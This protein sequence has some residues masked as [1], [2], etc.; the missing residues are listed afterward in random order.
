MTKLSSILED[1]LELFWLQAS[2]GKNDVRRSGQLVAHQTLELIEESLLVLKIPVD[3]REPHIGDLIDFP[4]AL[5][6]VFSYFCSRYLTVRGVADLRFDPVDHL[7][8]LRHTHR[9]LLTGL[10]ETYQN[11][12]PIEFL[13]PSVLLNDHVRD[14]VDPL[15]RGEP[16]LASQ[17]FP[18]AADG[19]AFLSL[20]GI[21]DFI[22]QVI[23]KRTLHS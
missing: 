3:R 21:H 5:H 11:L 7:R 13:A 9:A 23:A 1:V 6:Q 19:V 17:A 18:P 4:Q 14:F 16:A 8:Q 2:G 10:Q 20:S 22:L 12:L 15:I